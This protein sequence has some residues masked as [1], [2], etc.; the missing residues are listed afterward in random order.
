MTEHVEG[1]NVEIQISAG[2]VV[3]RRTEGRT[4]FLLIKDPYGN[5]GLP[6]GHIEEDESNE[7]AALREIEEETGLS[8]LRLVAPLSSIDWFF[9]D[10]GRLIHKYC[11]FFLVESAAGD[12]IPQVDEGIAACVWRSLGGALRGITYANARAVVREAGR[13]LTRE[14]ADD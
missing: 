2:G 4:R 13:R 6:K 11:H 8:D 1:A 3:Y 12:P 14:Q 9:R 10:D 7:Q 5:W